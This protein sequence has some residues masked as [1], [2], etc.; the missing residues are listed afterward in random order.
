VEE[1]ACAWEDEALIHS[2][3]DEGSVLE[4]LPLHTCNRAELYLVLRDGN[5]PGRLDCP[6][7]RRYEDHEVVRHLLRVLLGLES[8]ALG[9]EFIVRQVR[10]SYEN[11]RDE[12]CG[13]VLH[14]LFQ[15]A[16]G[17]SSSLR[18]TYHPGRA[19]SIPWLMV[20]EM[21]AA[22]GWE[23]EKSLVVGSGTM[24]QEVLKILRALGQETALTNRTASKGSAVAADLGARWIPWENWKGELAGFRNVY[25]CTGAKEAVLEPADIL[26][27]TRVFD[28][29]SPPQALKN[30]GEIGRLV[31]VD[32][33]AERAEVLLA[34]YSRKLKKLSREAE[35]VAQALWDEIETMNGRAYMRLAL[36]R[37]R[38]VA[39]DRADRT[40]DRN[41]YDP[42][43]LE[44]MAWSIV[45]GVLDP[46]LK[47]KDHPHTQKVWRA[48]VGEASGDDSQL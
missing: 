21:K 32:D 12:L 7:A 16:L 10:Q 4:A 43:V 36:S 6:G 38:Q 2:L 30:V 39:R 24:G 37:A 45:K 34:D 13:R 20:Q 18:Q 48:L 15:R 23:S 40:A 11:H 46:V 27:G 14:R 44:A 41:G 42:E 31:S 28:L 1:R 26:P 3:V 5:C 8:I 35:R 22:T 19:P 17:L 29:G 25:L 9:E 47:R 33:L